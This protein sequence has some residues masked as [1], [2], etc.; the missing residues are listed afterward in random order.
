MSS[1]T[2]ALRQARILKGLW[3][4]R[5]LLLNHC[6]DWSPEHG[7]T[8]KG[9]PARDAFD[10]IDRAILLLNDR[11]ALASTARAGAGDWVT[12]PRAATKAMLDAAYAAHDAYEA[13][14]EP[15]GWGGLGSVYKAMIEASPAVP[16]SPISTGSERDQG[17]S[18]G[19]GY[20]AEPEPVP[21]SALTEARALAQRAGEERDRAVA[22]AEKRGAEAMR[23]ICEER[24]TG[25]RIVEARSCL[26]WH[27]ENTGIDRAASAVRYAPLPRDYHGSARDA[28]QAALRAARSVTEPTEGEDA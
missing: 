17:A 27:A 22:D 19:P 11:A 21:V 2:E 5:D 14:P 6:S 25:L 8:V 26:A 4:A 24:V 7:T 20:S 9:K 13:A 18:S 1:E 12:V 10:G 28:V 3:A 23:L 15:K 16:A